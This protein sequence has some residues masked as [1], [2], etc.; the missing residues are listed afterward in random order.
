MPSTHLSLYYHLVFSTKNREPWFTPDLV[1]RIHAYLGGCVRTAGGGAEAIGGVA[2]HVHLL[3]SLRS[4]HKLADVLRD[5]QQESSRVVSPGQR[6]DR[7][8]RGRKATEH[9]L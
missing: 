6:G 1:P 3:V 9:S 4:T 2:D 8:S 5:V 7:H